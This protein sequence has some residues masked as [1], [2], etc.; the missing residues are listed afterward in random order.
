MSPAQLRAGECAGDAPE[1]ML[2]VSAQLEGSVE[3]HFVPYDYD[4]SLDVFRTFCERYGIE[5][6]EEDAGVLTALYEDFDCAP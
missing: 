6:S 5:V 2:D 3:E 1:L 4:V